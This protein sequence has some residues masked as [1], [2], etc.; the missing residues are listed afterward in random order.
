MS[1]RLYLNDTLK[2]NWRENEASLSFSCLPLSMELAVFS[3]MFDLGFGCTFLC[4][5][6]FGSIN[7][8]DIFLQ[9]CINLQL[10]FPHN[11]PHLTSL[12]LTPWVGG[13][14]CST[15]NLLFL[16]SILFWLCLPWWTMIYPS[17]T[18]MWLRAWMTAFNI[19]TQTTTPWRHGTSSS[20]M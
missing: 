4:N 16:E 8:M 11:L 12:V 17:W 1:L 20:H 10:V 5:Y 2:D 13:Y 19:I 14:I 6:S 18:R 3:V 7:V 15:R 9:N